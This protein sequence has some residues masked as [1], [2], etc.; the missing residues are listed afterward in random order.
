MG[1][2]SNLYISKSYQ[3]LIHLGSDN[4]ASAT[5]VGLQD[6]LGNSIGISVNT[7]GSLSISGSFT[8]SLQQGYVL[9][10]DVNNKT[11]LVATSSFAGG[12]PVGTATT[13]SNAF[14]GNQSISG[15]LVVSGSEIITGTL[16]ASLQQG[17]AW[18]GNSSNISTL[19]P[20][21]SFGGGSINTGSFATTGSNTF[22][23][24]QN[25][26]G[27]VTASTAKIA[28]LNYPTA[29]GIAGQFV[30]TNGTGTLTFDDVHVLLEDVRYGEAISIGDPLYVSGS[31]GNRAVVYKADASNPAK[32][33][34]IY[35]ASSTAAGNTNT[36]ALTLG[37]ITG[38]TTTGYAPGTTIYVGE[39]GGWSS[40]RPSG[41]ASIVQSLGIVTKE[42]AGGSG[43]GLVLN[44][45]PATLPNLQTGYAW[46]GNSGNQPVSVATSSFASLINTGSFATT[47]SNTFNGNQTI[48]GF[49]NVGGGI[50]VSGSQTIGA[51]TGSINLNVGSGSINLTVATGS[52][53]IIFLNSYLTQNKGRFSVSGPEFNVKTSDDT[54]LKLSIDTT[55]G[56][57]VPM[58]LYGQYAYDS[59]IVNSA[60][61]AS[62][63]YA[64]HTIDDSANSNNN[65]GIIGTYIDG[66]NQ[67]TYG[68]IFGG[69]GMTNNGA[70]DGIMF[71][72]YGNL[73]SVDFLKNVAV[74]GSLNLTSTFTSSLQQGYVWVGNASGR[75]T[76]VPTSSF[77]GGGAAFP[78]TGSAA[79]TGSLSVTGSMAG[80]VNSLVVTGTTASLDFSIGNMFTLTLPSASTTYFNPSNIKAGQTLNVQLTQQTPGTGSV[81][82]APS[83]KFAGGND[84]QAT[85]TGS[86]VDLI[87]FISL[88]GTNV[89]AT[90]IKN[91]L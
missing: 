27:A 72:S 71:R 54:L 42:G 16:T 58:N 87:T 21:S 62:A 64:G 24:S 56:E 20:T 9:V 34:V 19:V 53:S 70:N 37:L 84:Y 83:I 6:G 46:V 8:S 86:A 55:G 1:N 69:G 47:G 29:D 26:V 66:V 25:I 7:S 45:G 77:G 10:G 13:G 12:V 14:F 89:L 32:M 17:Y 68:V 85:A 4:T 36:T 48:N 39:G 41:S 31:N 75:T 22:N 38:V 3:S 81:S 52:Q 63:P 67:S 76:T 30:I 50:G 18:V 88:D 23:G 60:N 43:R 59:V 49:I 61:T 15:S 40:S 65:I 5:L 44:P 82:F 51:S 35:V 57:Y 90:S 11:T 79:I 80:R 73:N 91:F 78:Y 33:P 74:T 28:N 2:L